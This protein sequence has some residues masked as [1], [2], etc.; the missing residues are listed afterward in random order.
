MSLDITKNQET[1]SAEP[2]IFIWIKTN[3]DKKL[4]KVL[5]GQI[6][7]LISFN[8]KDLTQVLVNPQQIWMNFDTFPNSSPVNCVINFNSDA[9]HK[10]WKGL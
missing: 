3:T 4:D 10:G 8:V 9:V 7:I 1:F 6:F 5:P 2:D